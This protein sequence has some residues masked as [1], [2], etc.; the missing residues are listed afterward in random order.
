MRY[1]LFCL[2]LRA[3][4]CRAISRTSLLCLTTTTFGFCSVIVYSAYIF[5]E[6]TRY[7]GF[8]VP[9]MF[10][11]EETHEELPVRD[12]CRPN[13]FLSVN[14]QRQSTAEVILF[15]SYWC[16]NAVVAFITGS[17]VVLHYGKAHITWRK[18]TLLHLYR[19]LIRPKLDYGCVVYG[20]KVVSTD[21]RPYS[22]PYALR[23]YMGA[24]RISPAI[25][26]CVAA[27]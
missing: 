6:I 27:N 7:P 3:A 11:E 16:F 14:K 10:P 8:A 26:L 9:R 1:L 21:A 23:L 12:F 22:E 19:S 25:S 2:H 13:T 17:A 4:Y 15:I 18:E 24:L 5:P 20:S